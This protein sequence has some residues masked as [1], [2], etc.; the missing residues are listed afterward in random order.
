M[1]E[2]SSSPQEPARSLR[3]ELWRTLAATAV[4]F[5]IAMWCMRSVLP[6]WHEAYAGGGELEGW[7]WR[8]WWMKRLIVGAFHHASLAYT[9]HVA[10]VSGSYPQT[11]NVMDLQWLS[12]P[13]QAIFGSPD[14]Y[15]VKIVI[16]LVLNA[17]AGYWLGRILVEDW[18][19]SVLCGFVFAFGAYV[20]LEVE[21]GRVRQAL[22]FPLALYAITMVRMY[23]A[24]A[25][26][27][28]AVLAGLAAGLCS[29]VYLYYG[30]CAVFIT[31]MWLV[32]AGCPASVAEDGSRRA[33]R[34]AWRARLS[35][36][37]LCTV[38][39]VGL[40][41]SMAWNASVRGVLVCTFLMLAALMTLIVWRDGT[42]RLQQLFV[43]ATVAFLTS[44]PYSTWYVEQA[45]VRHQA[46]PEVSWSST[47]P[48]LETLINPP[49]NV[50]TSNNALG[51]SLQRFADDSVSYDFPF[52]I[53]YRRAAPVVV[54]VIVLGGLLLFRRRPWLWVAIMMGGY[55]LSLGP[56]L[57][58]GTYQTYLFQPGGLELPQA[59]FFKYVPYF[60]RLFS[61]IRMEAMFLLGFAVI[62]AWS[63]THIFRA[64][65]LAKWQRVA[66]VTVVVLLSLAQMK[67]DGQA[68]LSYTVVR[69]PAV[70]RWLRHTHAAGIVELP[71][72]EGDYANYYQIFHRKRV[73]DGWATASLPRHFPTSYTR[74]LAEA[75]N[76]DQNGENSF[77]RFLRA[78]NAG[79]TR[80]LLPWQPADLAALP[81]A[82]YRY[83]VLHERGC[84]ICKGPD[85]HA[86]YVWMRNLLDQILGPPVK[87]SSE[88]ISEHWGNTVPR[89]AHGLYVYE[90]AV[91]DLEKFAHTPSRQKA[92][93]RQG[94]PLH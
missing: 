34:E 87:V 39:V 76:L 28:A 3:T 68:P 6:H 38:A 81:A 9:M 66:F 40:G 44:L 83:A 42:I 82:G 35:Y 37:S 62:A 15:N 88:H 20:L 22:V 23:S 71:L 69:I 30:M 77:L 47:F 91:Y 58:A 94:Q 36:G 43:L 92:V 65:R 67:R 52:N 12:M 17:L 21:T 46:L 64:L 48:P 2:Q 85:G 19:A 45:F 51:N 61:P 16:V 49:H 74:W 25:P 73:L 75:P 57:R 4:F 27:I 72:R 10:L 70:Y 33:R 59:W 31:M 11:G 93:L 5:V 18:A 14:Y 32:W 7:L 41:F 26:L 84:F 90:I 86:Q 60:S 63:A 53:N 24:R 78:T 89:D 29:S 56:Y 50:H 13:L 80:P 54:T 1:S 8:Y 55:I 79:P